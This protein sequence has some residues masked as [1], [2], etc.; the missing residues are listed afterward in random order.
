VNGEEKL[1]VP[2]TAEEIDEVRVMMDNL[3]MVYWK[4][5]LSAYHIPVRNHAISREALKKAYEQLKAV[6]EK[7]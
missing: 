1:K 6:I 2:L 4:E 5:I 7:W 3:G